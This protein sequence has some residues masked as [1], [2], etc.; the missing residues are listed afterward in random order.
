MSTPLKCGFS[1]SELLMSRKLRTNLPTT[2]DSLRPAVPDLSLMRRREEQ[3]RQQAEWNY[4]ERETWTSLSRTNC[5]DSRQTG[6]SWRAAGSRNQIIRGSNLGW[7]CISPQQ[8]SSGWDSEL[9]FI[10]SERNDRNK[11]EYNQNESERIESEHIRHSRSTT[12]KHSAESTA[13]SV[14]AELENMT[15]F[16]VCACFWFGMYHMYMLD[17]STIQNVWMNLRR[18]D[19]VYA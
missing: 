17:L 8:T 11:F 3:M 4:M 12:K 7:W 10:Q 13:E 1:P 18:G 2:R 6:R 9:W 5:L 14:W 19:V 16:N 15:K